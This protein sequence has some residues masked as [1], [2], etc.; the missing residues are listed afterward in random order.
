MKK[1]CFPNLNELI[2]QNFLSFELWQKLGKMFCTYKHSSQNKSR[3]QNLHSITLLTI[4]LPIGDPWSFSILQ[5][6][7]HMESFFGM[8]KGWEN[9][10][11]NSWE[12][13][14][15]FCFCSFDFIFNI[16]Q[17]LNYGNFH[18]LGKL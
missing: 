12:K 9:I 16:P 18:K 11:H 8:K 14:T 4:K 3:V 15:Q 6:W 13:F 5:M 7:H 10:A 1:K 2:A 17:Y